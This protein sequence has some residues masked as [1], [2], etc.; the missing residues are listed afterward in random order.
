MTIKE[1]IDQE[2]MSSGTHSFYGIQA[3]VRK[4]LF[5]TK[6]YTVKPTR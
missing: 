4:F 3:T 2:E 5:F 1:L 6:K